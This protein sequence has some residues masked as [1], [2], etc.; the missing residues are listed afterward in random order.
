MKIKK[1]K[2]SQSRSRITPDIT[3][4]DHGDLSEVLDHKH[5]NK[6]LL[7]ICSFKKRSIRRLLSRDLE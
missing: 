7:V 4:G 6:T 5:F 3:L 1:K 2:V